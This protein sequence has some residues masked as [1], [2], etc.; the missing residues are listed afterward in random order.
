MCPTPAL[1]ES[2]RAQLP[3]TYRLSSHHDNPVRTGLTWCLLW[4]C[5]LKSPTPPTCDPAAFN[6]PFVGRRVT[7]RP[8][9]PESLFNTEHPNSRKPLGPGQTI[10]LWGLSGYL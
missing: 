10:Y 6:I 7:S 1:G 4:L 5:P 3:P 2:A 9:L 8:G